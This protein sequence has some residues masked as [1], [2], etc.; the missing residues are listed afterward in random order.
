MHKQTFIKYYKS[1]KINESDSSYVE[2]LND[3][4]TNNNMPILCN[5]QRESCYKPIKSQSEILKSIK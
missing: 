3:F 2:N 5:E 4:I 1:E